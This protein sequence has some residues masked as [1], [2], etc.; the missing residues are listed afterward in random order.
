MQHFVRIIIEET[1]FENCSILF[2][3]KHT[4]TLSLVAA[5]G[6]EDQLEVASR[7]YKQNLCFGSGQ[8]VAGRVF[9]SGEA[10]FI[11][12]T[13]DHPIPEIQDA[14]VAPISLACVPILDLGVINLSAYHPQ[15]FPHHIKRN[16][17]MIGNLIGYL[18]VGLQCAREAGQRMT[19]LAEGVQI[20]APAPRF[21]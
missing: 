13:A 12:N 5:Y 10:V 2:W 3:N 11:E 17:K 18:T 1:S 15:E 16:W 9:A 6:L 19:A 21:T 4:D 7:R 20:A 8:F 14:V